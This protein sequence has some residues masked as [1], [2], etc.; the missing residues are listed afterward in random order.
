MEMTENAETRFML[1]STL[2]T[3]K[4]VLTSCQ[5]PINLYDTSFAKNCLAS[6][7]PHELSNVCI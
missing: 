1:K 4:C 6:F 5:V 2:I 3:F 7:D